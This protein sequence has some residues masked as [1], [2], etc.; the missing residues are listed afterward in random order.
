MFSTSVE[1]RATAKAKLSPLEFYQ[2]IDNMAG[3]F[4]WK[5]PEDGT[6]QDLIKIFGSEIPSK[7]TLELVRTQAVMCSLQLPPVAKTYSIRMDGKAPAER[8]VDTT[9]ALNDHIAVRVNAMFS[10]GLLSAE[11][12]GNYKGFVINLIAQTR[13]VATDLSEKRLSSYCLSLERQLFSRLLQNAHSTAASDLERLKIDSTD[14]ETE[15]DPRRTVLSGAL[16]QIMTRK[17]LT[18]ELKTMRRRIVIINKVRRVTL[19]RVSVVRVGHDNVLID[20]CSDT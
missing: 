10:A 11:A 12:V 17:N 20:S 9:A 14:R 15:S 4:N 18:A 6:L 1:E 7:S 5:S 8:Y 3:L 13:A 16:S 19:F 2:E